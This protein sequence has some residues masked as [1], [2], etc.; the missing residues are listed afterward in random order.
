MSRKG[1]NRRSIL[2]WFRIRGYS[3][4]KTLYLF[5]RVSGI[6][7]VG[8]LLWHL[9]FRDEAYLLPPEIQVPL[10]ILITFHAVNGLRLVLA[11]L[12]FTVGKPIRAVFPY[13]FTS[14]TGI[15]RLSV[16]LV[17]IAFFALVVVWMLIVLGVLGW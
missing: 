7:T 13:V 5:Q 17:V 4:E 15:Q 14:L 2:E 10:G 9:A 11:E 3:L 6:V 8:Y 16:Y 1:G 12:G